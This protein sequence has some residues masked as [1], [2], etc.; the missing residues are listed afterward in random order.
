MMWYATEYPQENYA[1]PQDL[2]DLPLFAEDRESLIEK[3]RQD[4]NRL[5]EYYIWYNIL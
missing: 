1:D 5:Q 3:I 4:P 2:Q